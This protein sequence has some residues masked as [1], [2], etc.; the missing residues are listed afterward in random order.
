MLLLHLKKLTM[1]PVE[2]QLELQ[3]FISL[4]HSILRVIHSKK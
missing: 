4:L 2:V 1:F 3:H